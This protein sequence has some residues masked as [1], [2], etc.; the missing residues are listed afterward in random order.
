MKLIET[1]IFICDFCGKKQFRKSDMTK[2]EKW[3]KKNPQNKHKC[4]EFCKHLVKSR[5]HYEQGDF[6]GFK[7]IFT[8]SKL[9]QEM[10]SSIA[11]RRKLPVI[12]DGVTVRMPLE[13]EHYT[14]TNPA[15][16]DHPDY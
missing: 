7:T 14:D 2:H 8:C 5:E 16:C 4:F 12:T 11:E 10:Y 9:N 3:C 13:C 6:T 1:T 15:Y